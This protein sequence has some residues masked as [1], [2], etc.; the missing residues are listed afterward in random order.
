MRER[1]VEHW[2]KVAAICA[3]MLILLIALFTA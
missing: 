2:L 1:D 3:L